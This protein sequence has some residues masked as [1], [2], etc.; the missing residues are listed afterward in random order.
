MINVYFNGCSIILP[1]YTL[2]SS[3][4]F[5]GSVDPFGYSCKHRDN[6]ELKFWD[7]LATNGA[8]L[9]TNGSSGVNWH[10]PAGSRL[11]PEFPRLNFVHGRI[12][13]MVDSNY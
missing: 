11:P 6:P 3:I 7:K 8:E 10:K 12:I 13:R 4:A 1:S 5:A 9:Q 2:L